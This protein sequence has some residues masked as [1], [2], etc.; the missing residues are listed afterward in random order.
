MVLYP[1]GQSQNCKEYIA[2]YI[3]INS[4]MR[5]F[6]NLKF[7]LLDKS[8]TEINVREGIYAFA[9]HSGWGF[10]TFMK[11]S[12]VLDAAEGLL[13]DDKLTVLCRVRFLIGEDSEQMAITENRMQVSHDLGSQFES[14]TFSDI[15]LVA[16]GHEF[17]VHRIILASRSPV[18]SA[19]LSH[20]M[21]EKTESK[22]V[23]GDIEPEVLKEMLRFIYCGDV[24]NT[25]ELAP[26]LL[27]VADKYQLEGL[28][29]ACAI[30]LRTHINVE[31]AAQILSLTGR[32][33]L[34]SLK[35]D[36][37]DF[38]LDNASD[39]KDTEGFRD[40]CSIANQPSL[41]QEFVYMLVSEIESLT[42]IKE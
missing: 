5:T 1:N 18:F 17:P 22:V 12:K 34:H 32:Y 7:S 27:A 10:E 3:F 14:E 23:I 25:L 41:V 30:E 4:P 36:V 11:R 42:L 33:S 21:R 8:G 38:M 40:L 19:M 28:A 16:R 29:D 39:V 15:T 13:V 20:D 37:L 24:R 6:A 9:E 31:N 26:E 2:V 35:E